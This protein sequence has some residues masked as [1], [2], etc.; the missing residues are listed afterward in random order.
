MSAFSI[1]T[2]YGTTDPIPYANEEVPFI[3]YAQ[4][5]DV[6][7]MV[8]PNHPIATIT[9]RS[10]VDWRYE[11]PEF[12]GGPFIDSRSEDLNTMLA[13]TGVTDTATLRSR[14]DAF[15]VGDVGKLVEYSSAGQQLLGLITTY[16]SAR[17]V[18]I[19]PY[20]DRCLVLSKE[21]YSPGFY[22]SWDGTNS[23]P[24]Y[25][26]PIA[27]GASTTV[28]FSNSSAVN[29][30]MIGNYLRFVDKLGGYWW[31]LIE[32]VD[33]IIEQG[34][35]GILAKGP[36]YDV[37]VP[38]SATL[39]I[40]RQITATLTSSTADFFNLST[41][42]GRLFRLVL[43]DSVRTARGVADGGNNGTTLK[44]RLDLS[45]PL[46]QEGEEV[47]NKGS[48]NIWQRGAWFTGNYPGVVC[49][50]EG[51][52]CFGKTP[53]QPQSI[54]L[55]KSADFYDF[56]STSEE[57]EVLADSSINLPLD[58][59]TANE[60]FW[61]ISRAFL[62]LGASGSEWQVGASTNRE[63]LTAD[64]ATAQVQSSHGSEPARALS[65]GRNV[66]FIQY[67]G[68]KIREM[69]YDYTDDAQNST[70][71]NTYANHLLRDHG[72]AIQLAYQPI[73]FPTVYVLLGD[74]QLGVLTYEP[75]QQVYAWSRYIVGGP[76]ARVTSIACKPEGSN[77]ALYMT[78]SRVVNGEEVVTIERLIPEFRP[79]GPT[80]RSNL[81]F[82]D[83][84]R[85]VPEE[86]IDGTLVTGL[87]DFAGETVNILLDD[88]VYH[89]LVVSVSGELT[90]PRV[91]VTRLFVGYAYTSTLKTFPIEVQGIA[92]TSQGKLGRINAVVF[93]CIDSAGARWGDSPTNLRAV[94][95]RRDQDPPGL[96]PPFRTGDIRI[97]VD[98][99]ID[100]LSQQYVVQDLA[101]P[102]NILAIFP[103]LAKFQ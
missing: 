86:D 18:Q 59:D 13:A 20:E 5:V 71:L 48:T 30:S 96:P 85:M 42:I 87:D 100:T 67:G 68:S 32:S 46:S 56:S 11:Q 45:L 44:V 97:T 12:Y 28:A 23:I 61:M 50:H 99:G 62:L 52:L 14:A 9:R 53:L 92:G 60:V 77:Y 26:N 31:M 41:D 70:D 82:L 7:F 90:L 73:P 91:P 39:R 78:V 83:G 36:V 34:A 19:T 80:D 16:T 49:F 38:A 81:L 89:G 103:E 58:S 21:T 1:D 51:R 63:A 22:A 84:H 102:L 37:L 94:D 93:R 40:D 75:D 24:V 3:Q 65:V 66:L 4:S 64:N 95:F 25:T 55:S 10:D 17:Q 29:R 6:M 54:W 8:H 72:G 101:L 88:S 27:P 33:N 2:I 76:Q 15:V 69:K 98:S 43:G 35:Y 79:T 47:K 57:Q 74:G